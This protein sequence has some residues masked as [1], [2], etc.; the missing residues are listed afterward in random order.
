MPLVSS[1][2]QVVATLPISEANVTNLTTDLA[3][4]ANATA[5]LI[6]A[7]TVTANTAQVL[8]FDG[9][10]GTDKI[11]VAAPGSGFALVVVAALIVLRAG[12]TP[13]ADGSDIY[14]GPRGSDRS[15]W[16]PAMGTATVQAATDQAG[17]KFHQQSDGA[18]SAIENAALVC[19]CLGTQFTT[20]NGSLQIHVAYYKL[21][22]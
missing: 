4:K 15:L 19:N 5:T 17:M 2:S 22:L 11:V 16:E 14:I 18:L 6:Q 20:G 21:T 12:A 10:V 3:A 7:P 8:A 9:N 1:G 13:F